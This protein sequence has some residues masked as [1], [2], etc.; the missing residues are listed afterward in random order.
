ML[1]WGYRGSLRV[2]VLPRGC[3]TQTPWNILMSAS[4]PSPRAAAHRDGHAE[5]LYQ[6]HSKE[7]SH[8]R[9]VVVR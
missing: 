9:F 7:H 8:A 1:F 2:F 6:A 5:L 4:D 3:A